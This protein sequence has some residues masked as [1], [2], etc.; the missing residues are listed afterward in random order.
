MLHQPRKL[1]IFLGYKTRFDAGAIRTAN[2]ERTSYPVERHNVA[3]VAPE[4]KNFLASLEYRVRYPAIWATAPAI[5][6]R[7]LFSRA[8]IRFEIRKQRDVH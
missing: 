3:A 4:V 7:L 2:N 5:K 8:C 1:L 6:G